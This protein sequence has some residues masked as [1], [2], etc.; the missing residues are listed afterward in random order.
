MAGR[1]H[2]RSTV[3]EKDHVFDLMFL[4]KFREKHRGNRGGSRRIKPD[5][6]QA[7]GVGI[8]GSVQPISLVIELNHGFINCNVI[9]VSTIC[10]L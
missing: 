5:V 10:R 4:T 1:L 7:V 9:R 2:P 3:D 8:D 6:E